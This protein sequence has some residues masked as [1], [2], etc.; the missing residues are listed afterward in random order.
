M[1]SSDRLAFARRA[2]PIL[3]QRDYE[4]AKAVLSHAASSSSDDERFLCLLR[5]LYDYERKGAHFEL[6]RIVELAEWVFVP[7]LSN[8]QERSR[9]WSDDAV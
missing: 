1:G 7:A 6:A 9:R 8:P 3:W 5:A 4:A 2:R